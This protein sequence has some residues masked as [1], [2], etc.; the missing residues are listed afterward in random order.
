MTARRRLVL[1]AILYEFFA[2]VLVGPILSLLFGEPMGAS[3]GLAALLSTIALAWSYAFNSLF[4][5][6]ESRQRN[7]QRTPF[8]R[9]LHGL[10]FEGGLVLLF[11]PVM[12]AWLSVPLGVALLTNLGLL[13][14]FLVYAIVF[15]WAFDK[16]LGPPASARARG[17]GAGPLEWRP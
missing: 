9:L 14:F 13:V 2:I 17:P 12:A 10:G 8:R 5:A 6:W 4:E 16:V 15:T 7:R 1:Q 11:M 3:L